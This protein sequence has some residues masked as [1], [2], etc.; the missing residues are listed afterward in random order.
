M[1][2]GGGNCYCSDIMMKMET[3]MKKGLEIPVTRISPYFQKPNNDWKTRW[4]YWDFADHR[5]HVLLRHKARLLC[6]K[7]EID[8]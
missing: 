8:V 1:T 3:H 6:K 4:L 5:E 2:V 7:I